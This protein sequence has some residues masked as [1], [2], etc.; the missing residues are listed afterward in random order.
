[1][2]INC[3]PTSFSGIMS[4]S[5]HYVT[6]VHTVHNKSSKT[7]PMVM[8]TGS[9]LGGLIW[10]ITDPIYASI[11]L[12]ERFLVQTQLQY[13]TEYQLKLK[14]RDLYLQFQ[15]IRSFPL[16]KLVRHIC[17]GIKNLP[18]NITNA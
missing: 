3:D 9:Y 1:M 16:I 8:G 12:Q 17:N 15:N 5:A 7:G 10:T 11:I 2:I 4:D 13:L 18:S 6:Y 14:H